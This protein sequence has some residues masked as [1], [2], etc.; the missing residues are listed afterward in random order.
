MY[1]SGYTIS[2]VYITLSSGLIARSL[3]RRPV[4]KSMYQQT[5]VIEVHGGQGG[6]VDKVEDIFKQF[7]HGS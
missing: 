4:D 7:N 1:R 2:T 3:Y 5:L 6:F